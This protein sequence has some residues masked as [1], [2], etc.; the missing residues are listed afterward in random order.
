MK[1]HHK[2]SNL[3][4]QYCGDWWCCCGGKNFRDEFI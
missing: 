2:I 3:V 1:K 4:P